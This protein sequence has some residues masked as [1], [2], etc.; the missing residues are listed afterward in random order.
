MKTCHHRLAL[1]IGVAIAAAPAVAVAQ[2]APGAVTI[3][4]KAEPV[5]LDPCNVGE[6]NAAGFIVGQNL[7][8]TLTVL[9]PDTGSVLPKLATSWEE[10]SDGVWRVELRQGVKFHDSTDFNAAAVA[11]ALHRVENPDLQCEGAMLKLPKP[12]FMTNVVDDDTLDVS[13]TDTTL[14]LPTLLSFIGMSASGTDGSQLIPDP[15]GTGPYVLAGW[16]RGKQVVLERFDGYW[17]EKPEIE[18]ATYVWREEPALRAAMV[19]AGEADI[20][21]LI[22]PQNAVNP[23]TDFSYLSGDTTRVRL[24]LQPPLDDIRVRKALNLAFDRQALIGSILN[25]G[26]VPATQLI[27]PDVQGYDPDLKVLPFDPEQAIALL[28]EA[29]ADG[30]PV[31]QEMRFIGRSGFFPNVDEV[32]QAM[33][34]MWD[35]VGFN[36]KVEMMERGQFRK[37]ANRPYDMTRPAMLI[38]EAHDNNDGDAVF[39]MRFKYFSDGQQSE[40]SL[41]EVDRLIAG[42]EAATGDARTQMFREANRILYG[43]L[44]VDVPMYHMVNFMRVGPRVDYKPGGFYSAALLPLASIKPAGG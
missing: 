42:G 14:P 33:A 41:P 1:A 36:I 4:L 9:D 7:V 17:G 25:E 32:V 21:L 12:K 18:K 2:N 30:V 15:V 29:K 6:P 37:L 28:A 10:R 34:Q 8:E 26:V 27:L 35:A 31:D 24:V 20:G 23:E 13:N 44:V 22:A 38:Q 16:E 3:V 39:T 43:D 40:T 11:D 19:E 5:D